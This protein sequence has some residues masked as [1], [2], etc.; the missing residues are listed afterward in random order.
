MSDR[1]AGV[2]DLETRMHDVLAVMDAVG[3][4]R[5]VHRAEHSPPVDTTIG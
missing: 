3:S 2:P 1:P 5:A 4:T